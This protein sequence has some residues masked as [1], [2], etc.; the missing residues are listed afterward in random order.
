M[1]FCKDV[2][3]IINNHNLQ[4]L[5]PLLKNLTYDILTLLTNITKLSNAEINKMS[6]ASQSLKAKKKQYDTLNINQESLLRENVIDTVGSGVST[7]SSSLLRFFATSIDTIFLK[8][9]K[10]EGVFNYCS[11]LLSNLSNRLNAIPQHCYVSDIGKF[12]VSNEMLAVLGAG[13]GL[14]LSFG[15]IRKVFYKLVNAVRDT[16]NG[17]WEWTRR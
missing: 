8:Q 11:N 17:F 15:L 13:L 1:F 16:W 9:Q 3:Q 10:S 2:T 12:L 7:A 4:A 14:F 6:K 5:Q